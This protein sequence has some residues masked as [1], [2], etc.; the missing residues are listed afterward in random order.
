MK[1]LSD[2]LSIDEVA[3]LTEAEMVR[4]RFD[5]GNIRWI[6][7]L[8]VPAAIIGFAQVLIAIFGRTDGPHLLPVAITHFFTASVAL[9]FF[10]QLA[11]W[12]RSRGT[13]TPRLPVHLLARNLTPWVLAFLISE[14]TLITFFRDFDSNG[15][16]GAAILFPWL[17][18][19][20]GLDLSR[21]IALH[22]S[23]LGVM[24]INALL[25]GT[26]DRHRAPEYAAAVIMS[27]I[28]FFIGAMN[29]RRARRQTIEEWTERRAQARDQLRMRNELQY[30]REIQLSMLPEASPSLTWVDL[31]GTSLPATEVGG[32]YYDYFVDGESI[33]IVCGDVAGHGLGSG[34]VLASLRSGFTLL[35]ESLHDPAAVLQRLSDL[36]EQMS[37]R[38]MLAT[39]AVVRLN[40]LT[41][42]AT[43]ASAGH[44]PVL[45]H[46]DGKV[47]MIELFAPPLG[48]RLPHNVPSRE[49][50]FNSG[51]VFVLHSDGVYES[52]NA[53]GEIYGFDRLM[54]LLEDMDGA[55][56]AETRDAIVRDV[57][58]F[59]AGAPQDD[60]L[61][62]VVARV[63]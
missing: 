11:R 44:P 8:S 60:D 55:G 38:R 26:T 39:V 53:A 33:A 29:S 5:T 48:V 30:A 57:E 46:H 51:D 28:T 41:S 47:E 52:Q 59:R 24:V 10:G 3:S 45:L 43:V 35:R 20:V 2:S 19:P 62:L 18:V 9:L 27:S 34:I 12:Q 61:T 40:R 23:L 13:W 7:L 17:L 14:F 21:R 22:V 56:A 31:A 54:R 4:R 25:L 16:I 63:L 42:T 15:W 1:K 6:G 58:A 36:V 32:D 50:T 49:I 37:R